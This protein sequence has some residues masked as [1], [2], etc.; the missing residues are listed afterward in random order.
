MPL[1]RKI[2]ISNQAIQ[3]KS[4]KLHKRALRD[5]RKKIRKGELVDSHDLA[6]YLQT[7]DARYAHIKADIANAT[8]VANYAKVRADKMAETRQLLDF[9]SQDHA[10]LTR[11]YQIVAQKAKDAERIDDLKQEKLSAVDLTKLKDIFNALA[12]KDDAND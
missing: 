6:L 11:L 2:I 4:D 8:R 3:A 7:I 1:F 9:F 10:E 12:R 5:A